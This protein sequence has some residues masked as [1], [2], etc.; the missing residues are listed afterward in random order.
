MFLFAHFKADKAYEG[1]YRAK[2][3]Q[4]LLESKRA[5]AL[6][7]AKMSRQI[8]AGLYSFSHCHLISRRILL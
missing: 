4:S 6:N 3:Q 8:A 7:S 5:G 2:L 1:K